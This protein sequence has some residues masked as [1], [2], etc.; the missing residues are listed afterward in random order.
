MDLC[1]GFILVFIGFA[2]WLTLGITAGWTTVEIVWTFDEGSFLVWA[3]TLLG[4]SLLSA[5]VQ[6]LFY[7]GL[8][9]KNA[10]EGVRIQGALVQIVPMLET[11]EFLLTVFGLEVFAGA[12]LL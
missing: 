11:Y 4:M 8:V 3:V 12:L 5:W 2:A 6:D 9:L 7:L 10:A 1:A